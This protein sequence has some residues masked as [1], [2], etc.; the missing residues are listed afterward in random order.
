MT[1]FKTGTILT[2]QVMDCQVHAIGKAIRPLSTDLVTINQIPQ[3]FVI[4]TL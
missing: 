2:G 1:K 3:S 4:Q